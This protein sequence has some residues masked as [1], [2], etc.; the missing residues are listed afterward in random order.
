MHKCFVCKTETDKTIAGKTHMA[1]IGSY[2]IPLCDGCKSHMG[3]HRE[4][5]R[6]EVI[7]QV[8]EHA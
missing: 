4:A 2:E 1:P 5:L 8:T 7:R 3:E 6:A